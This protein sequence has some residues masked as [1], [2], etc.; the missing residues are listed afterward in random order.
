M[1]YPSE[2]H[3]SV[4]FYRLLKLILVVTIAK[5]NGFHSTSVFGSVDMVI[6]G[7]VSEQK[8]PIEVNFKVWIGVCAL[9]SAA[10]RGAVEFT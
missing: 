4:I 3:N 9:R 6:L 5:I 7:S 8:R 10:A 1:L 2:P